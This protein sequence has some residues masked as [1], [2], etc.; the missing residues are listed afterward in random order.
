MPKHTVANQI[1]LIMKIPSSTFNMLS[2]RNSYTVHDLHC[3]CLVY[4]YYI[5]N[6]LDKVFISRKSQ[7]GGC[8][9]ITGSNPE[10]AVV[11]SVLELNEATITS[12]WI[13]I[14]SSWKLLCNNNCHVTFWLQLLLLI[15]LFYPVLRT[16]LLN[17]IQN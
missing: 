14:L 2:F 5:S 3:W 17:T 12:Y 11:D 9:F 16:I 7:L 4:T 13:S 6:R 1:V 8:R 10:M 15:L